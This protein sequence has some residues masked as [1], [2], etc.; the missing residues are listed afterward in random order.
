MS[1]SFRL[2]RVMNK[3][4][5]ITLQ[6]NFMK[7]YT[8]LTLLIS[9]YINALYRGYTQLKN[10]AALVNIL[11]ERIKQTPDDIESYGMLGST[12]YLMGN[13]EK[14]IEVWNKPFS[15]VMLIR[16]FIE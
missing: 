16:Y 4:E 10:Y 5:I 2:P 13:E 12:Y 3:S 14:A 15:L 11:D 1:R 8:N 9:Q 6:L 7:N